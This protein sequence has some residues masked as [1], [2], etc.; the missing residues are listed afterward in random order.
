[1]GF[2]SLLPLFFM[3]LHPATSYC[4]QPAVVGGFGY[5]EAL[6]DDGTVWAWGRNDYGQLGDGT[7][8][9]QDTPV[10]VLG[11][12]GAG[13][14]T[15]VKAIAAGREHT[16]ALKCDG[17]VWAWG[18]NIFGQIGDNTHTDKY[19][20][21]Q[22][23]GTDSVGF[24]TNVISIAA[25]YWY[26]IALKE[27]GTV[28]TWG[29]GP[30]GDNT[31][32]NR[33]TPVQVLGP[34]GIG[35]LTDVIAI[36]AGDFHAMAVKKDGSVWAWGD[37]NCGQLGD[38]TTTNRSTPVQVMGLGGIGFLAGAKA[39]A[40]GA[41]HTVV[42]KDDGTLLAW[43]LNCY[44]QLGDGTRT[45]QDTPVQVLGLGGAGILTGVKAIA[46]GSYHTITLK[47]DGTVWTWGSNMDGV[48]GVG[49][50]PGMDRLTPVK[51]LGPGGVGFLTDV[52]V[53]A[54]GWYQ[55]MALKCDGT[56]WA[57][58]D[59]LWGQLGDG[60]QGVWNDR[61]T[62]IQVLGPEGV[63]YLNLGSFISREYYIPYYL[64]NSG[65]WTGVALKNGSTPGIASVD[66][67][68]MSQIGSL[69]DSQTK[70]IPPKGQ[71]AFMMKPG[72]GWAKV[73]S[74][75]P[76]TG[77]GF[78]AMAY[79]DKLMFDIP[80]VSELSTTLYVPHVAQDATWDTLVYVCNP[81]G[82]E[83]TVYLTFFKSDGTAAKI[84][85]GYVLSA[86]GSGKY[87]LSALL[88]G[89]SYASGSVR[90]TASQ[91][92]AAFALYNNLKTGDRSYAGISAEISQAAGQGSYSYYL[93]YV[94]ADKDD[95]TGVG[96]RNGSET[97]SASVT[98]TCIRQNGTTFDSQAKT[99]PALGQTAFMMK[100]GEGWAKV[101]SDEPLTG[102]G[103][104]AMAYDDKLMFDIP[105]VS[106]PAKTLYIPH[107]AQDAT[108]DTI[109]YVCNPNGSETTIYL[110][111][112]RSDGT[113][114]TSKKYTLSP[115]GSGGYPLS[116]VVGGG[117]YSSGSIEITASQGVAAF[118]LYHNLKT[119]DRSYAGI[120]AVA[121]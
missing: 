105:F 96:L 82:S 29:S 35:V 51:A 60:T 78:I 40:A 38:N 116:G 46:S 31:T 43:G 102:L 114:V 93:P 100:P 8:T 24:L 103:F 32:T 68:S 95:W 14:L 76:L 88:G 59:N 110:T 108:W 111:F 99:I 30:M 9:G 20:P 55:T 66:V 113:V 33:K 36:A 49:D 81:N 87:P 69:M 47:E 15:G 17:T 106:E 83:T 13:I 75:K 11:L 26:T 107:V 101:T 41:S 77:L 85:S 97:S 6:K 50:N 1:M 91:G 34:G 117:S 57:W 90:I 23:V 25:G 18:N 53:V 80:F 86:N 74:D 112:V 115:N 37:N 73:T 118:A 7:R 21:V 10:Q 16:V 121:P 4:V 104:I 84:S 109:V 28:W 54:A 52:N 39:I 119:G 48:L 12:G 79:D 65:Y 42:L 58:G 98:V 71:T 89:A 2:V 94:L 19:T 62:P 64:S 72:E 67:F 120:S 61:T 27:D 45:G 22:V 63:G 44:G 56:V 3:L 92:V 5:T 70:T